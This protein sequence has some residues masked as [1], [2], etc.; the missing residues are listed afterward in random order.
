MNIKAWNNNQERERERQSEERRGEEGEEAEMKKRASK[1]SQ[2]GLA[3]NH[4]HF[5]RPSPSTKFTSCM[6]RIVISDVSAPASQK[7]AAAK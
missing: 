1:E 7:C 2:S 5:K 3:P 6:I 4:S